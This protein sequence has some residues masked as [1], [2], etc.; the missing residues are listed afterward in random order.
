MPE[1]ASYPH[2]SYPVLWAHVR[3][4]AL[5]FMLGVGSPFAY[6][7][8]QKGAGNSF[9]W[10]GIGL[11]VLTTVIATIC[12]ILW[13]AVVGFCMA[14]RVYLSGNLPLWLSFS[15]GFASS[16]LLAVAAYLRGRDIPAALMARDWATTYWLALPLLAAL[17]T[18]LRLRFGVLRA[19]QT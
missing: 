10:E 11:A 1:Q 15:F 13:G 8:Y 12:G 14:I 18:R 5:I 4:G 17:W 16:L 9:L 2:L 6:G 3:G 7:L 19:R